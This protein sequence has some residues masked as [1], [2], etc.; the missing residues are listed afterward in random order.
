MT[1]REVFIV[2]TGVANIASLIAAFERLDCCAQLTADPAQVEPS[3][4]AAVAAADKNLP[5]LNL[6]T[7]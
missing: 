4:R 5:I 7:M 1:A 2:D 6:R 3:V